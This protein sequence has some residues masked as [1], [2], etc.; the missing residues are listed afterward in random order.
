MGLDWMLDKN[1]ARPGNEERYATVS[2]MLTQMREQDEAESPE[3][4]AELKELSISCYEVVGAPQVGI[5]EKA[6]EWYRKNNYD[7]AHADAKAGKLDSREKMKEL[8]EIWTDL[9]RDGWE[10]FEI[11]T[12]AH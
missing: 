5:D 8:S 10:L 3:L 2:R 9:P 1:K 4:E 7:P 12:N 11:Q 6:T